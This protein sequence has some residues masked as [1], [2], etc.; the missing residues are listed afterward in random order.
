MPKYDRNNISSLV[1]Q[2]LPDFVSE[3]YP[4]FVLF[5]EEYYKWLESKDN[6]YFAPLSLNGLV[7]IDRTVDD[8]IKYFKSY[9]FP[10]FP[11]RY[12][13]A[14]GDELDVTLTIK[15]IRDFYQSKGTKDSIKFLIRLLF[16]V[17][18]EIY[19][20]SEDMFIASG[21]KWYQPYIV[22]CMDTNPTRNS[23]LR[24]SKVTFHDKDGLQVATGKIEDLKQFNRSSKQIVEF[25]IVEFQGTM[26]FPGTIRTKTID[27]QNVSI[28]LI[29][30]VSEITVSNGGSSYTLD[31][32]ITIETSSGL[33]GIGAKAS[34]SSLD[35]DGG[36]RSIRIDD[37]GL[38]YSEINGLLFHYTVDVT[39]Q[40]GTGASGFE[41]S[42]SSRVK[43]PGV[44]QNNDGQLSSTE[45]LQDNFRYQTHSYVIRT[46]ANLDEYKDAVKELAHPAGKLFLGDYFVYRKDGLTTSNLGYG[47]G[48]LEEPYFANYFP[49]AIATLSDGATNE[50]GVF[51]ILSS[52]FDL[53]GV[54]TEGIS[55]S[56]QDPPF[57]H[58]YF[59]YGY[60]GSTG[61]TLTDEESARSELGDGISS[62]WD[63][64]NFNRFG[65]AGATQEF[66]ARKRI[67]TAI[68]NFYEEQNDNTGFFDHTSAAFTV[69]EFV[70]Q[71]VF[72][73]TQ[74]R[75]KVV[76]WRANP[77]ATTPGTL[78]VEVLNGE[79]ITATD[80]DDIPT[81]VTG[82][83]ISF[84]FTQGEP[85]TGGGN[86]KSTIQFWTGD[87]GTDHPEDA[88]VIG[89]TVYEYNSSSDGPPRGE[90]LGWSGGTYGIL[91]LKLTRSVGGVPNEFSGDTNFENINYTNRISF[92]ENGG[93]AYTGGGQNEELIVFR[94]G[95]NTHAAD[96]FTVGATVYQYDTE[97]IVLGWTGGTYGELLVSVSTGG[98]VS[99]PTGGEPLD[100]LTTITTGKLGFGSDGSTYSGGGNDRTIILFDNTTNAHASSAFTIG[101][102]VHQGEHSE[103]Q[104][105]GTV[106]SWISALGSLVLRN[107]NGLF[108]TGT[109]GEVLTAITSGCILYG[110][111]T[112]TAYTGGGSSD[113]N[114]GGFVITVSDT[115]NFYNGGII[116][117]IQG[118]TGYSGGHILSVTSE[119]YQYGGFV[120][121]V[122]ESYELPYTGNTLPGWPSNDIDFWIVHPHP[123]TWH[124]GIT[125]GI[126]WGAIVLQDFIRSSFSLTSPP[127][128]GESNT[129]Q[130]TLGDSP[131]IP[132]GYGQ[133]I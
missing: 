100:D 55:G 105:R 22:R 49:Y 80:P 31:D 57:Y 77:N 59:P 45:K 95:G 91:T 85:Y 116:E 25:D 93:T 133:D 61:Y 11:E 23:K 112:G 130:G 47:I 117:S 129:Q 88:F 104:A 12:K 76:R 13:S 72:G 111:T 63:T 35:N 78:T 18:S 21:G 131:K 83:C 68:I 94:T 66:F 19:V 108:R 44:Y 42:T 36:I 30:M 51:G 124:G 48:G 87:T 114:S 106:I 71:G 8:Y 97:G 3:D 50:L 128:Y 20:P 118:P 2:N 6:S 79:F 46:E 52:E 67:N 4:K 74:A 9:I 60:D 37:P 33:N 34:V 53:R 96:A 15:K 38:Y 125:K 73:V 5:V 99:T 109:A 75:G 28:N 62:G 81:G 110:E 103:S 14:K 120:T 122:V 84:G 101:Q 119:P 98:F 86:L 58:D 69:G 102:K 41:I 90:V 56:T 26:P 107:D 121:S 132:D 115:E 82:N 65:G 126:T 92:V 1:S 39:S 43:R 32:E 40:T 27:D 7:D 70:H 89:Q 54:S 29:S 10:K 16:D 123:N 64:Q 113:G 127:E 17:Y 24:N